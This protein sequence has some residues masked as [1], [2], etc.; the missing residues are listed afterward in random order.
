MCVVEHMLFFCIFFLVLILKTSLRA[1][2]DC[3]FDR[4]KSTNKNAKTSCRWHIYF[5]RIGNSIKKNGLQQK[6]PA[7]LFVVCSPLVSKSNS[8]HQFRSFRE[9][10]YGFQ[11]FCRFVVSTVEEDRS[12]YYFISWNVILNGTQ[13]LA[14]QMAVALCTISACRVIHFLFVC[15][16]ETNAI[17]YL[18]FRGWS[19]F[20]VVYFI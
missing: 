14:L 16:F 20:F 13:T 12:W 7:Y 18:W 17:F 8:A 3:W 15:I 19:A 10:V 5:S 6:N 2:Y 9:F 1:L 4:K 11:L